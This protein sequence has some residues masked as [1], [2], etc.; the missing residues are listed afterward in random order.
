MKAVVRLAINFAFKYEKALK[1]AYMKFAVKEEG[2]QI[3]QFKN[4][5]WSNSC[6]HGNH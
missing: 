3:N 2:E 5:R 4:V 1:K 6:K